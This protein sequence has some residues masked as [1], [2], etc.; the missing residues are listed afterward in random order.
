[1]ATNVT[2]LILL[3][4]TLSSCWLLT[5]RKNK[6]LLVCLCTLCYFTLQ[7]TLEKERNRTDLISFLSRSTHIL[8]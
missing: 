5:R 3:C 2:L 6:A 4:E 1:M 7:L 8:L